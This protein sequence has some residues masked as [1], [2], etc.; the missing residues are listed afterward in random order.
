MP[1]RAPSIALIVNPIAGLGGAVGLKGT[2]G[3]GI[4]AEALARGAVPHAGTRVQRAFS[5]LSR[6][7][8][9]TLI[10]AAPGQ[11]GVDWLA[12]LDLCVRPLADFHPSGTARDTRE[13]TAH[14][15]DTDL[16]VFGGGD[17]TARD[18]TGR[19][20]D[21]QAVLGIPCGVKM[22]S[23]VFAVSPEA[24]GAL[25][26]D[27][28]TMPDRIAWD[29]A[30]EV[31][32]IDEEALRA[33]RIAPRLFGQA[34]VPISRQRMQASKAGPPM[35]STDALMGAA[36]EI[37]EEMEPGTLYVIGPGTSAG[38]IMNVLGHAPNVLGIDAVRDGKV[39]AQDVTGEALEAL[40]RDTPVRI[41][42]GVTGRQGFLLG[43]GNQQ[44]TPAMIKRS[45][46]DG[47]IVM[48][49]ESKLAALALPRLWVDTGDPAL[50]Q[51]L[52][53]YLRVKTGRG[54]ETLMRVGAS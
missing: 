43:R 4:V 31:M 24:A 40:V 42:L 41:V 44:I 32:D 33:G 9:G 29:P 2:D 30:A 6:R 22:H 3:P 48:A 36:H 45:G 5:I 21:N 35:R 52:S 18:V 28:V 14:L 20:G 54:R 34:R 50:D 8:P 38:L 39:I 49:S 26:A 27:L 25:L 1:D 10:R 7:A 16:V 19:V 11:L 51:A 15:T 47:L 53:G 13:A 46:R 12:G 23:G 17:G 37:V